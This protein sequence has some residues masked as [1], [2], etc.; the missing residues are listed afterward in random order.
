M[1]PHVGG[2]LKGTVS[3]NA[4][5]NH[6]TEYRGRGPRTDT[7]RRDAG[8]GQAVELARPLPP[9]GRSP[10][11]TASALEC[12]KPTP[13]SLFG[14]VPD[15]DNIKAVELAT[16]EKSEKDLG[17]QSVANLFMMKCRE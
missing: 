2:R 17:L 7:G 6:G 8:K 4:I 5:K 12:D 16:S 1:S 3:K 15:P 11:N 9:P 14:D 10:C 13:D